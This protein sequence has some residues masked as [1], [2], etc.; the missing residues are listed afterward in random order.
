M[1]W[2]EIVPRLKRWKCII[3]CGQSLTTF[4]ALRFGSSP[5]CFHKRV[6]RQQALGSG[7]RLYHSTSDPPPGDDDLTPMSCRRRCSIT[8]S[9]YEGFSRDCLAVFGI[10]GR[11]SRL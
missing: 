7:R 6:L 11:G 10:E 5:D 4:T 2:L 1:E 3:P 9:N 8:P